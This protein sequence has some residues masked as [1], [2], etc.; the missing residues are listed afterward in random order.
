MRILR[1]VRWLPLTV[2]VPL[3]V[4]GLMLVLGA[5]ASERVLSKLADLQERQLRELAAL[6][7]D[8]LSVAV[9][10][11]ALRN[12][13]W[14]AFDALDRATH[15]ERSLSARVTTL[16]TDDGEV[17]ASSDPVRFPTGSR[18]DAEAVGAPTPDALTLGGS[19]PSVKVR[20]PLAYQGRT[21]GQL[22]AE[23]DVSGL[24]AARRA[25]MLFLLA[26]NAAA[27]IVLA[28]AGYLVV[29]RMLRPLKVLSDHMDRDE[30]PDLIPDQDMPAGANEFARLFQ[31]YNALVRAER[32]RQE[33]ARRLAEEERLVSLGRLASGVA[34]EINNPL[35]GLLNALD[36]LK[37]HGER[38]GV[39]ER[40]LALLERG[41][42]GI[43]DIVRAMIETYRPEV[44]GA[45]L[46]EADLE[47]L[48]LLITPE[49]RRQ[50]QSL[51]WTIQS[52]AFD[53][54]QI[55]SAPV[56]QAVLNLLL[57]ASAA[58][59][60][61]GDVRLAVSRNDAALA[62][63]V[64]NSGEACLPRPARR[65][66]PEAERS[67]AAAS[68]CA[69][70]SSGP[71]RWAERCGLS[72]IRTAPA[73]RSRFRCCTPQEGQPDVDRAAHRGR[74]GRR[75]HGRL[76]RAAARAR[77]CAADLVAAR[78]R[79]GSGAPNH[80][81]PVR[82]RGLRHSSAR[83]GRRSRVPRR[84]T[85]GTAA[86]LP[87]HHRPWRHRAGGP[88]PARRRR[89][90]PDQAVRHRRLPRSPGGDRTLAGGH[91]RHRS[92]GRVDGDADGRGH[93]QPHRRHRPSGA[94]LR[95]DRRRQ[96]DR[97]PPAACALAACRR[98]DRRGEL[99]RDTRRP[100][101]ERALRP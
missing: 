26:G 86:A 11:A 61:G 47:D 14:E 6:Y 82:R 84:R 70:S 25:A 50:G 41:L 60:T 81:G 95:G 90:L 20:A 27:T 72:P 19:A 100:A 31:T 30:G 75:D 40:S 49:V 55:P 35:G 59:G 98:A 1:R 53:G 54:A 74:R 5:I 9:L 16:A 33:A 38:P 76:D 28:L 18:L 36:T 62:I 10:P 44:D 13:V 51:H 68:A 57:N 39:T 46:S 66:R 45:L 63:A 29:R 89:R 80:P 4:V 24:L 87:V 21:V 15:Q 65:W 22:H 8:G 85:G 7:F 91:Q 88:A 73:S 92:A 12:D 78:R 67:L 79:R 94:D 93:H 2:R 101:R 32:D 52:G 34:H 99:R 97:R 64:G 56:R 3:L 69:S 96:G 43:R 17:V 58:A 42:V 77:G 83:P 37:R 71:V 23:L 48:R